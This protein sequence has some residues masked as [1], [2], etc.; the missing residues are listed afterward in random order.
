MPERI[1]P[2]RV[3]DMGVDSEDLSEDCFDISK[4]VFRKSSTFANPVTTR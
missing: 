2:M 3:I 4:E 1:D